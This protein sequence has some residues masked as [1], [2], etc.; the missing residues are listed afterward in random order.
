MAVVVQ[1]RKERHLVVRQALLCREESAVLRLFPQAGKSW[2]KRRLDGGRDR[3][4][5]HAVAVLEPDELPFLGLVA[6]AR[7]IAV[8]PSAIRAARSRPQ[9]YGF[10]SLRGA[11]TTECAAASFCAWRAASARASQG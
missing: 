5:E 2:D 8:H 3:L 4:N 1:L 9:N 6:S 11:R 10:D 7:R